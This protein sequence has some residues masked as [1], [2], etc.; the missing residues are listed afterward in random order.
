M[1]YYIYKTINNINKKYYIGQRCYHGDNILQ[2]DY[3]GSGTLLRRAIKKYGKKNF[4]KQILQICKTKSELDIIEKEIINEKI[5]NDENSYNIALGGTG[6]NL[7]EIINEKIR[8]I[9]NSSIYKDKMREIIN[10]PILK[11]KI[12]KTIKET[13]SDPDW[14]LWF[15]I[16]QKEAK[17]RPDI[18]QKNSEV[19]KKIQN[20]PEVKLKK[21]LSMINKFNDNIIKE[22]HKLSCNTEKF[23][24]AQR[25]TRLGKKWIHNKLSNKQIYVTVE[26]LSEYLKNGWNLGMLSRKIT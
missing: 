8:K 7:G 15:S 20:T 17:N 22:K 26:M 10:N 3:L 2:D 25:K 19:Q 14:K 16:I 23:K 9:C 6:G 1:V 21:S 24:T 13:M 5:I 11:A 18:R 12:S 4:E